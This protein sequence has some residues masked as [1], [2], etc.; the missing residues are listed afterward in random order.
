VHVNGVVKRAVLVPCLRKDRVMPLGPSR[1][2]GH[3]HGEGAV[4]RASV[5]YDA[6]RDSAGWPTEGWLVGVESGDTH[7]MYTPVLRGE[8]WLP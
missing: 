6:A 2:T 5:P 3:S 8:L 7:H 1:Q 4:V